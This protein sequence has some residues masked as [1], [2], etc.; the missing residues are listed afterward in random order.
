MAN[1]EFTYFGVVI[2]LVLILYT[3][4]LC[5]FLCLRRY[6]IKKEIE[7]RNIVRGTNDEEQN[8][9][10]AANFSFAF[11]TDFDTV[12]QSSLG[13]GCRFFLCISRSIAF[14]FFF[15]M[16]VYLN[17]VKDNHGL[18]YFTNWNALM[19]T[20]YFGTAAVASSIGMLLICTIYNVVVCTIL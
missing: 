11:R 6:N 20:F 4:I 18:I 12:T 3:T 8:Y 7:Y 5:I 2:F 19:V 17:A 14:I 9:Y 16:A 15:I 10:D 1:S 13:K